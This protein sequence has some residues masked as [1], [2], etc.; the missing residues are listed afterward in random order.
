MMAITQNGSEAEMA[1]TEG[2]RQ[3]IRIDD[4][5]ISLSAV[6]EKPKNGESKK[7]VILLHGFTSAKDRPHNIQA[8]EAMR[9]AGYAT[10]RFDLYGHGE[11]GGEFRKH[12][13]YKWISNTMA[14]IDFVR[15]IGY[16]KVYLSGH[17]QGGLVAALAAGMEADRIRGLILR[18]PAFMIP[19]G[20]RE[21][22]LLGQAFDPNHIP[23]EVPVIK[24][25]TLEGNY[26]RVAQTIHVEDAADRY[27]GP[28]LILHGEEDDTVPPDVSRQMAQRYNDC[29]LV[30]VFGETHHFDRKPE[31]M[32]DIIREWL[33]VRV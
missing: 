32:K 5:G 20:A 26:I 29:T 22:S 9:E 28:V 33:R 25:L 4:D 13:L 7:I 24:G 27:M 12:T 8:A 16:T 3:A 11:S 18:A 1:Y 30:A 6:L 14:V 31:A 2:N 17:S 23:E 10:L 15:S 19:Q 21:G